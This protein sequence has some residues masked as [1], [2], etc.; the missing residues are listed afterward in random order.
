MVKRKCSCISYNL[1]ITLPYLLKGSIL[2]YRHLAILIVNCLVRGELLFDRY[3][4]DG[5]TF[6]WPTLLVRNLQVRDSNLSF[7]AVFLTVLKACLSASSIR[8]SRPCSKYLIISWI[9]HDTFPSRYSFSHFSTLL[10]ASDFNRRY[11]TNVF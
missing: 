9:M 8:S 2:K 11:L 1:K 6:V 7:S 4:I 10:L 5:V 3:F